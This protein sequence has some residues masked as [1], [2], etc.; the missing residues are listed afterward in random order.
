MSTFLHLR[1]LQ[2][3]FV[4]IYAENFLGVY[5]RVRSLEVNWSVQAGNK[6]AS[7][8]FVRCR[9]NFHAPASVLS[10]LEDSF[11][12]IIQVGQAGLSDFQTGQPHKRQH[13]FLF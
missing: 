3:P 5:V 8:P 12:G 9:C 4:N 13:T 2:L 7:M 6:G 1:Q 11:S 10:L